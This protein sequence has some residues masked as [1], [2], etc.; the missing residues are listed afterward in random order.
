MWLA[1]K[2]FQTTWT[3]G[4]EDAVSV[5]THNSLIDD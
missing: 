5:D 3:F 4:M 2:G 1:S